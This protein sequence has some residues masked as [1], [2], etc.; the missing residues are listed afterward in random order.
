MSTDPLEAGESQEENFHTGCS[1]SSAKVLKMQQTSQLQDGFSSQALY[2]PKNYKPGHV[3]LKRHLLSSQSS[4]CSLNHKA[5][6][7]QCTRPQVTF[8]KEEESPL[9]STPTHQRDPISSSQ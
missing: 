7:A 4:L 8:P 1:S 6:C 9:K 5:S 2:S 3:M